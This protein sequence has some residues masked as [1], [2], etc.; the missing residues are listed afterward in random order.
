MCV[1]GGKE[2][3]RVKSKYQKIIALLLVVIFMVPSNMNA[4]AE[5]AANDKTLCSH[6]PAHT[7]K[8]GFD[9]ETGNSSCKF[10]C[11]VCEKD[12][13]P[14]IEKSGVTISL[15]DEN[16]VSGKVDLLEGVTAKDKD[17][18]S[19][20]VSIYS[21][22]DEKDSQPVKLTKERYL[23]AED[24]HKYVVVYTARNTGGGGV[25]TASAG[26][27]LE[28]EEQDT[29]TA[30]ETTDTS[31][32]QSTETT[33][34]K[35]TEKKK[36]PAKAAESNLDPNG[37]LAA[38]EIY[39]GAKR[40]DG[41]WIVYDAADEAEAN[42]KAKVTFS[43]GTNI[44]E[45]YYLYIKKVKE[46][47]EHYPSDDAV[48]ETAGEY[49]DY[50]CYA[51]HWVK[52]N[53]DGTFDKDVNTVLSDGDSAT[54]TLE[55]LK[56][57]AK[58]LG[59][60]AKRKLLIFNS[61][62]EGT[63]LEDI[64]S[65][66]EDVK[67]G[68]DK[69]N[70][71]TFTTSKG[72]PYVFV[73]KKL[74]EA[75]VTDLAVK[76]ITD[77]TG[78]FDETGDLTAEGKVSHPGNDKSSDNKVVRSF[79]TIKYDLTT[80]FE[81]RDTQAQKDTATMG[82]EMTLKKGLTEAEFDFGSMVWLGDRYKIEY[83]DKDGN[84]ICTRDHEGKI[85]DKDGKETTINQLAYGSQEKG[86]SYRVPGIETQRLTG[87]FELKS[88][89]DNP[90]VIAGTKTF[91]AGIKVKNVNNNDKFQPEFKF[92]FQG[93]E[94]NYGKESKASGVFHPAQKEDG[95]VLKANGENI[96][97][98]S[99]GTNFNMQ[100][101]KNVDL[102][103]K[104][105]F[106]F[107]TGMT[108]DA[109]IQKELDELAILDANK[110]KSNPADF[111]NKEGN[112]LPADKKNQYK[113]Y[114]YGRISGYG[115]TLQLYNDTDNKPE[116][117]RAAK[118]MKGYSLPAGDITF[119]LNFTSTARAG[120]TKL[121]EKNYTPILWDYNENIDATQTYNKTYEGHSVIRNGTNKGKWE[122][123]LYWNKEQRSPYAKGAA[124]GN[125]HVSGDTVRE[126]YYGGNWEIT[127]GTNGGG[128]WKSTAENVT[129]TG[130]DTT[131]HFQVRDYDFDLDSYHFP[132]NDMGNGSTLSEYTTFA[133]GFSAGYVQVLSVFPRYQKESVVDLELETTVNNLSF[134]TRD[135]TTFQASS[136]D[137]TKYQHEVNKKDNVK[138]DK[139]DLYA[140]G[141]MTK[142]NSF[143]QTDAKVAAE[144]YLGTSYWGTSY[145]C[146]AFAGDSIALLGYGMLSSNS[147]YRVKSMNLLQLFDSRALSI[148]G[149]PKVYWDSTDGTKGT[150]KILYAADPDYENGY[151]TNA[152]GIL[153][154]MNRVREED[155]V[156]SDTLNKD[157]TI[158]VQIGNETKNLKCI[159][160]MMELR[161]CD[162]KGGMYQ[163]LKVPVKV[164]GDDE[165]LVGKT[166][167][168]VNTVRIWTDEEDMKN[169]D[170]TPVSWKDG[171]WDSTA[172]KNTLTHYQAP[173]GKPDEEDD[174][175]HYRGELANGTSCGKI[176]G[177]KD[178]V[179]TEYKD[180]QQI[181]GTHAGGV[182]SGNSLLILGYEAQ[183]NLKTKNPKA[184][185]DS[186]STT[187]YDMD[188]GQNTVEYTLYNLKAKE[189]D[190]TRVSGKKTDLTIQAV[191]DKGKEML[192]R[193]NITAG[194]YKVKGFTSEAEAKKPDGVPQD[195]MIGTK[196]NPT[197]VWFKDSEG[198]CYEIQIYAELDMPSNNGIRF[199]LSEVP[200]GVNLPD[201]VFSASLNSKKVNNNDTIE[202]H[203]YISGEGD[204]RAYEK[205]KGNTDNQT[206]SITQLQG[207]A[208]DKSVDKTLV[209]LND[210]FEYTVK[211]T[212]N[213][214]QKVRKIYFYDL[215]PYNGDIRG[216]AFHGGMELREFSASLTGEKSEGENFSADVT[217]YYSTKES[218]ELKEKIAGFNGKDET[219]V[220]DMLDDPDWFHK[221]GT[222]DKTTGEFVR[223]S[224]LTNISDLIQKMK[225]LYIKVENLGPQRTLSMKM[226]VLPINT[227]K[228]NQAAA[229]LYGN[230]AHSWIPENG[231]N[232]VSS[233]IVQ[234]SV[235]S[236]EI[237]GVV[238]YDKNKDGVRD[239]SEPKINEVQCTLFK[240]N[241]SS[242]EVCKTD[243]L[244]NS[245]GEEGTITTEADGAY[246]FEN[247]EAG[248]Y[249]VAFKGDALK[250]YTGETAYQV[251]GENDVDTSD[252]VEA[253]NYS[254]LPEG[255]TYAI[256][257]SNNEEEMKLHTIDEIQNQNIKLDNSKERKTNQDL[258]LIDVN[259]LKISKE[260]QGDAADKEKKFDFEVTLTLDGKPLTGEYDY[261]IE[262]TS[263]KL[264]LDKN[265]KA[266]L[267]LKHGQTAVIKDVPVGTQ[268][269]VEEVKVPT[270]YSSGITNGSGT[271]PEKP[272]EAS[273][274][275]A[276]NTYS[277]KETT[278]APKAAKAFTADSA[279]R[280]DANKKEFRFQLKEGD[281]NPEN[282]AELPA[283]TEAVIMDAGS[284]NF[285]AIT[286]KKPG[287][288]TFKME[289]AVQNGDGYTCDT[290]KWTLTIEVE[291][292]EVE[293]EKDGKKVKV[294]ALQVVNHQYAKDGTTETSTDA[295]AFTNTYKTTDTAY[296]PKVS[297]R[298]AA[299][300]DERPS[301]KTFT[302]SLEDA[303]VTGTEGYE[304]PQTQNTRVSVTGEGKGSFGDIA[305]TKAGTY[306]F[307]VKEIKNN[308]PGYTYDD[309]TWTLTVTV[310]DNKGK[311]KAQGSYT[312][313]D[314]TA[315]SEEAS[316][317]NSYQAS[318]TS[319][320][321]KVKKTMSGNLGKDETFKFKI[322]ND[323]GYSNEKVVMPK[324]TSASVTVTK[325]DREKEA[326][327]DA[328]T[329][330]KAGT[331]E[332]TIAEE[333]PGLSYVAYDKNH[334]TLT[335]EIED[336]NGELRVKSNGV[337]YRN[338]KDSSE[339]AQYAEFEN[340][341]EDGNLKI[342]KT[343]AGA[344]GS[345]EKNFKFEVEL[346][347]KN[348]PLTGE[349]RYNGSI[350]GTMTLNNEGKGEVSLKH[351]QSVT[352]NGLPKGAAYRVTEKNQNTDA[353][354]IWYNVT[355]AGN[356]GTIE[357][358]Q[359]MSAAFMNTAPE[360]T[361]S[362]AVKKAVAGTE[363]P[364][365][366]TLD[367]WFTFQIEKGDGT[368]SGTPMPANTEVTNQ[369]GKVDFG[370]IT[371][372]KPG[373][374][375]YKI[376][377]TAEVKD[378]DV[379]WKASKN[380]ITATVVVTSV[381]SASPLPTVGLDTGNSLKAVVTYTGG[382]GQ[383][384]DTFT[385]TYKEPEAAKASFKAKKQVMNTADQS[386]MSVNGTYEFQLKDEKGNVLQTKK[387]D[388]DGNISFDTL[389]WNREGTY[390]YIMEESGEKNPNLKYD[391]TPIH[392][393]VEVSK[394]AAIN[395][396]T[397]SV[398]YI[399]EN[400]ES[401]EVQSFVN[402]YTKPSDTQTTLKV[403]KQLLGRKLEKQQFS[404]TLKPVDKAP[405]PKG[406]D[407][408]ELSSVTIEN[409]KDGKVEF[410]PITFT[411]DG[412]D[413]EAASKTYVYKITEK[414]TGDVCYEY[415][416]AEIT[417][418]VKVESKDHK[419]KV[420]S[421]QY[422]KSAKVGDESGSTFV[423][424][425][426]E[427][428]A[429]KLVLGG[430]KTLTG[431]ELSNGQFTFKLTP[432]GDAPGEV[433]EVKNKADGT[434]EFAPIII[435]ETKDNFGWAN[436]EEGKTFTYRVEEVNDAKK[437]Y[438]YD[439]LPI[440]VKV[441][442]KKNKKNQ[443]EVV[444]VSYEKGGK[445]ADG[446]AF[447]NTFKETTTTTT[448]TPNRKPRNGR[449]AK[450]E[451][452]APVAEMVFLAI[453]SL[454]IFAGAL[455]RKRKQKN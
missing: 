215:M 243:K 445:A 300:G 33:E 206:I 349:Y 434:F 364:N 358:D 140:I 182:Q 110:G 48:K 390:N 453:A 227:E 427:P 447:H 36:T 119:D 13:Y 192:D 235:L 151:D 285:D 128:Q 378:N 304:M 391:E 407:G 171:I 37:E 225:G 430:T 57:N 64:S 274:V 301:E 103:Y 333:D 412:T 166:I 371:Y 240:K 16:K 126:C 451:D 446:I 347:L 83:L 19:Y 282:G 28:A 345:T 178:Y 394:D 404:F 309:S 411:S 253:S 72:G 448:S 7:E 233:T 273:L 329:F 152:E 135:G 116:D 382:D 373:I 138:T 322:E 428:E 145:D 34:T 291:D 440:T 249:V 377:E 20:A 146:S 275:K 317:E 226:K 409:D 330:K 35:S 231:S 255:Y 210:F 343:V 335:V 417:A 123:N 321:P 6:H 198:K 388:K 120:G 362:I 381:N 160:V 47:E 84:V 367:G 89:E 99:A 79:D 180:G 51:I 433:Q 100:L 92:W 163:Y 188:Q 431:K 403:S 213:S 292:K 158:T 157:G 56:D 71:F 197:T 201:I 413:S 437:G 455:V 169:P 450:T 443:L 141:G 258:G 55:Y 222:I 199:E 341:Y 406:D 74:F 40:D 418:V 98:V 183:V 124:P 5:K 173:T 279:D 338:K 148:N 262:N 130:S 60:S 340:V 106:D 31:T 73:S 366:N 416:D 426:K 264:S 200:I 242:Y 318:Q 376:H 66:I 306:T 111:V 270:G 289:E 29:S 11:P 312:K 429:A 184:G 76:E 46:G 167:A 252:G 359:T 277:T 32:D 170:N 58:L 216:S 368:A 22:I 49:N 354:E 24:G 54:I 164:N 357:K 286:F 348:K 68:Q 299:N 91:S 260:V 137:D 410:G 432:R 297:K 132:E 117:N 296:T 189:S 185:S 401:E 342:A 221:L 334:W 336:V 351:G 205:T 187:T 420:T 328:I 149:D 251:K 75:Y 69:Y 424:K 305:F 219:A 39:P 392:V 248:D 161:E 155:L 212:N 324:D 245:I 294:K 186:S 133:K 315:S 230:V 361:A 395:Q 419:L 12:D 25:I 129:G 239:K 144:K 313:P 379:S 441:T 398:T 30:A 194:T 9:Q 208:I 325:D 452:S 389:T 191:A 190:Q 344:G 217:V 86:K 405:M 276:V 220:D 223:D 268:Y 65:T 168:A 96:V 3:M 1:K 290:S 402:K 78:P 237:S 42:V 385:N 156:Y 384:Q 238:W 396:L 293:V 256:K 94:D 102:T 295:A 383:N 370:S 259:D 421:V 81:Q 4:W 439:D 339:N 442:V 125:Y 311:L 2:R 172:G 23:D 59:E 174:G 408:Q 307:T 63:K 218:G 207:T 374:Y 283:N 386:Q 109:D 288:Y 131:Y 399:K 250:A 67:V 165:E 95:N 265:G 436:S 346:K 244:G 246:R 363:A 310:T 209:E 88:T 97:V 143:N 162:L 26:R 400:I 414:N 211:Y 281:G 53:N 193:I 127:N 365:I 77:G 85:W 438:T 372:T 332:F 360:T 153:Q 196:E 136:D 18:T 44:P 139:I 422:E 38:L 266:V 261:T 159:G 369:T 147:D 154:Y 316:F 27:I 61:N 90:N 121:D 45:N 323:K 380:V 449:L 356:E 308:E 195:I 444:D 263:Q 14:E 232:E 278:F 175:K 267:K 280:P 236:R 353:N 108:V 375:I 287:T 41:S 241:G 93:N 62:Q 247:L 150:E 114:R 203:V 314:G 107:S 104:N 272:A 21:I 284:A 122:R 50:Q 423:N 52:I 43:A 229:D 337:T 176:S 397:A 80:T 142:G 204:C 234:T 271:I 269:N 177:T 320:T 224:G 70:G 113:N 254:G 101:K 327:F 331:Y 202:S 82:F 87:S 134:T 105:W 214:K 298:F 179:K 228:E 393:K 352:I 15:P 10:H 326:S 257:Y 302:F 415:D 387:N 425:Y 355:S 350:S 319:Y 454:A 17:G 112:Q 8:C 118:G 435:Q 181:S 115:I 303:N